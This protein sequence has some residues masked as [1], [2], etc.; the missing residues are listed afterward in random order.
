MYYYL[1]CIVYDKLL[2]P[3]QSFWITLY[4]YSK[5]KQIHQCLIFILLEKHSTCFGRSSRPSSGVQ[6]CTYSN[7]HMSN[8]YCC[9]LMRTR[10]NSFPL[11]SRQQYLFDI[12]L[13]LY[14]QSLT[15]DDG[16]KGRPKHVQCYSNKINLRHWC[17]CLFLLWKYRSWIWECGVN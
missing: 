17:I 12:C 11:A 13:L 5:T 1:R 14:L 15:P 6:D 8:R 7:T 2:K 16:R 9:L 4:F 10:W 3:R